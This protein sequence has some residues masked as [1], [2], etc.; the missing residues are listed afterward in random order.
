MKI[1]LQQELIKLLGPE[2][3]T[4]DYIE[5]LLYSHDMAALPKVIAKNY[6]LMPDVVVR[7]KSVEQ[8]S[9][10]LRF[11]HN[12]SIP[13]VPR[14]SATT[15][16]GGAIPVVGGIVLDASSLNQMIEFDQ[17][18]MVVKV[19]AGVIC[20]TIL[21]FLEKRGFTLYTYP[22]S[23]PSAT[24]GG[25]LSASGRGVGKAGLGIGSARHGYAADAVADLEV[26]LP[27]GELLTS[28]A[29]SKFQTWD[30]LGTDGILG[31][32]TKAIIRVR[33][34]PELQKSVSFSF[35]DMSSLCNVVAQGASLRPLFAVFEDANLLKT[36]ERAGL[37]VPKATHMVTFVLEGTVAEVNRDEKSL[38]V[39]AINS[40]G[41]DLGPEVANEE[42][43][44]RYYPMRAKR[45]GPSILGGEFFIPLS[46]LNS[47]VVKIELLA[48]QKGVNIGLHG[49][50]GAREALLMA[51]V[52]CDERKTFNYITLMSLASEMNHLGLAMGGG[53]YHV[54]SFN[55]FFAREVHGTGFSQLVRLKKELDPNNVMNT[56]KGLCHITKLGIPMPKLAYNAAMRVLSSLIW[57]GGDKNEL[58]RP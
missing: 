14:G 30:F 54:G 17:D 18:R 19:E 43:A 44:E 27:N 51:Q 22:T 28:V 4:A 26:V 7:P 33:P 55:A 56:G 31:I 32:I 38:Q 23:S 37:H 53:P 6:R 21:K 47:T 52:L 58:N 24:I 49:I 20:E 45:S 1:S 10:V 15:T 46:Q 29:A 3:A 57:L 12:H 50:L 41:K 16:M 34:M 39:M 48:K 42:W 36:K 2:Y 40:G 25:W 11:A 35:E 9:H 13:V 8:V 5:R